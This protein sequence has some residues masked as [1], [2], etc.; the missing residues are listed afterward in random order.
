MYSSEFEVLGFKIARGDETP[1]GVAWPSPSISGAHAYNCKQSEPPM[2]YNLVGQI[3]P[4]IYI[5]IYDRPFWPLGGPV[6]RAN[7]AGQIR[8]ESV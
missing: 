5:F 1:V 3:E 4:P 2:A 8:I 7:I 6:L